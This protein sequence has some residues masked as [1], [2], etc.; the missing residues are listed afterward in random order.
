MNR[1]VLCAGILLLVS[2]MVSG[3]E[4]ETGKIGKINR[5]KKEIIVNMRSG[6]NI[7]MGDMLEARP[8]S[9]L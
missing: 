8:A 6:E 3:S 2:V 7:R 5:A 9:E 4:R 1:T